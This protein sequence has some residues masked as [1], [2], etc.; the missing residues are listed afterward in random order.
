MTPPN[1]V[2]PRPALSLAAACSALHEQQL[3]FDACL[4]SGAD[5]AGLLRPRQAG[6]PT[7]MPI[8]RHAYPSRL[9]DAL[10]D[11]HE[12]LAQAMGD[13]PF[14]AL[15]QAYLEARPSRR[16]SIRWFGD[17]LADF[18]RERA[19]ADDAV[20]PHPAYAD[21]AAMDWALRSAFDAADAPVLRSD[22]LAAVPAEDWPALRFE[23]HP[24]LR[25]VPLAWAVEAAWQVL[26]DHDPAS[27]AD[28]P[29]LPAPEA[30]AH[31]LLVWRAGLETRWRSLS[32][33]ESVLLRLVLAGEDFA[34]LCAQCLHPDEADE[35]E[36]ARRAVTALGHWVADGLLL[37][38][39][40]DQIQVPAQPLKPG[41][42]R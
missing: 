20:V 42:A 11:N 21:L 24:S 22:D 29:E 9:R 2:P 6:A 14:A 35:S 8:Y 37:G 31:D 39:A 13:A 34:A 26:R 12:V 1:V 16:P 33:E 23:A 18:M 3:A 30:R 17:G 32:A 36:A 27:D 25:L 19:E 4:R 7:L 41:P 10:R 15:A 5:A 28:A 38:R 40:E